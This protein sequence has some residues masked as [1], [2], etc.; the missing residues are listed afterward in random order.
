MLGSEPGSSIYWLLN[1]GRLLKALCLIVLIC[2]IQIVMT[3]SPWGSYRIK[4][5]SSC[6]CMDQYQIYS[7]GSIC[8]ILKTVIFTSL[9]H[10]FYITWQPTTSSDFLRSKGW[11][12]VSKS[13]KTKTFY[14]LWGNIYIQHNLLM[15]V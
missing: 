2:T 12:F 6:K 15:K 10:S 1:T 8:V 4:Y 5:I 7:K 13:V 11:F 3:S 14:P 9:L